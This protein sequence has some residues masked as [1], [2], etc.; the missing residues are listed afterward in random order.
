L[1]IWTTEILSPTDV[2]TSGQIVAQMAV[3]FEQDHPAVEVEFVPKKP[4]GKGGILDFLMT[5]SAVVPDL[6]PDLVVIDVNELSAIVQAE[7]AQPLDDLISPELVADLYPFARQASTFDGQL[8]GLQFLADL[9]HLV[10]DTGKVALAPSAWPG[11]LTTPGPHIFP[12]GGQA[13]LVNDAF[14]IQYLAVRA[15]PSSSAPPDPFLEQNSLTAVLQYYGDGLS[16]GIF[17]VAIMGYHT[18]DECWQDFEAGQAA[19]SHV[20][21]HRYL[22]ERDPSSTSEVGPIPTVS[23]P[24]TAISRGWAV[25][26]IATDPTRQALAVDLVQ[27][28]MAPEINGP[29]NQAA[30][31]LPTRQAALAFWDAT[32]Y[33]P[34]AEQQLLM[35]RPRPFLPNYTAIASALQDAVDQVLGGEKTPEEAATLAIEKTQP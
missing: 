19:I 23:G 32:E 28:W 20:S 13:G 14:L 12:A 33:S 21:A 22:L 15:E 24:G 31:Y 17:P 10:Y 4:Y 27:R 2:I 1:T 30:S 5:T 3:E 29:W 8:Y 34:F 11:V 16:R 25:A 9:D 26:L 35:A 7:L 6:L 18:T